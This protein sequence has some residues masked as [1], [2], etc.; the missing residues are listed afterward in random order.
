MSL[1]EN[2][3]GMFGLQITSNA[4]KMHL[5]GELS[6]GLDDEGST[7]TLNA[8]AL[9]GSFG[10]YL[11]QDGQIKTEVEAIRKYREMSLFAEVD[12]AIQEIVNESIPS[13]QD[14]KM[15]KLDLDNLHELSDNTKAR[16]QEQFEKTLKL[17]N[18]D[19][20]AAGYFKQWYVDGRIAFQVIVDKDHIEDGIQKLI[21]LDS[22]NL[23]KM[24]DVTTKL[25]PTGAHIIEKVDE[26]FLYSETGFGVAKSPSGS[27]IAPTLGLKI[28]RDAIIFATSGLTDGVNGMIISHLNKAIRP[29]NQLR[30]LEDATVVYFI[31]RAPERRVFYIDVGNLPKLKAEQYLKDIMNR[32]RNKMVYDSGTGAVRSD[33]KY[34]AML[35]DFFLPRRE[36]CFALDTKIPL[37]DGRILELN[38]IK[39]EFEDGKELWAYSCDPI[40]GKFAPGLITWAGITRKNT[41]VMRITLDNG[42]QMTCTLDHKFPVWNKGKTEAKDLLVGDSMIPF[43]TRNLRVNPNSKGSKNEYHQIFKNDTKTWDYTHRLVSKWK[44]K[45]KLDNTWVY[46]EVYKDEKKYTVHHMDC[47]FKNNFPTNLVRMHGKDHTGYHAETAYFTTLSHE[48]MSEI[49]RRG[50]TKSFELKV[51]CYSEEGEA[52]RKEGYNK[53]VDAMKSDD[54]IRTEQVEKQIAGWTEDKR[55]VASDHANR[56]GLYLM[57]QAALKECWKDPAY[58]ASKTKAYQTEYT[59]SM[60]QL[61]NNIDK[62]YCKTTA[63]ATSY[64]NTVIDFKEWEEL[65]SI[66]IGIQKVWDKLARDDI[67]RMLPAL[68]YKTWEEFKDYRIHNNHKIVSIEYLD[69]TMDVGTLTIDGDEIYHDY[70]TFALAAGIYTYNSKGTEIDSLPGAQNITGYLDSLTWFKEKMY[71]SLNIPKSRLKQ[72]TGFSMG[73]STSISRD[74]VTFQKFIDRL[75]NKFS[76]LILDT[77]ATQLSLTGVVNKEE[78]AE[79]KSY[80][81]FDFQK[82]NYFSELKEQEI[83]TSRFTMIQQLDSSLQKYISKEWVQRTILQMNDDDIVQM[84]KQMA[85]EKNDES[86]WPDWKLQGQIQMDQQKDM[87]QAQSDNQVDMQSKM[88]DLMP[89]QPA[90]NKKTS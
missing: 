82:D 77:L 73:Q 53:F 20:H 32:Y 24:K 43:Y 67:I 49:G 38:E 3:L 54:A 48:E 50:G 62:Q 31:A 6:T 36:G 10:T 56:R 12:V 89:E 37:L 40:T 41:N 76:Q 52:N 72:E 2:A 47:D 78:W 51:G 16:I 87:M 27:T 74:E 18:Y 81:K 21:L 70:H 33:K 39:A 13:E 7:T 30:M 59:D 68:G 66:K 26:Y 14:T 60:L 88:Q 61:L 85:K 9:A 45:N 75:R 80:I 5:S 4:P 29:I 64:L 35:E 55:N 15:I 34:S 86:C 1:L 84:K 11:D 69:E 19:E 71:E 58:R 17:L 46:D 23:K 63:I 90:A 22:Q 57:G 44:D 8:T 42:E 28:A 25:S 79:I 65:N 83:W